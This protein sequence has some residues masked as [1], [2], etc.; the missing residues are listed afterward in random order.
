MCT[1]IPCGPA[2]LICVGGPGGRVVVA[3]VK[4]WL[5]HLIATAAVGLLGIYIY[6]YFRILQKFIMH[7]AQPSK[8]RLDGVHFIFRHIPIH[9]SLLQGE[10][11]KVT[12]YTAHIS[13]NGSHFLTARV[14]VY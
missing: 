12:T 4:D 6:I 1:G 3:S 14:L 10:L 7:P 9:T 13:S 11:F 2:H 5:T 8:A